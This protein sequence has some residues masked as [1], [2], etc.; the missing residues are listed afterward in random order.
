MPPPIPIYALDY[1]GR[2]NLVGVSETRSGMFFAE[3]SISKVGSLSADDLQEFGKCVYGPLRSTSEEAKSDYNLFR[4]GANESSSSLRRIIARLASL[5][6]TR[7]YP[8]P[9]ITPMLSQNPSMT[10]NVSPNG[11]RI[12][13]IRRPK[14]II[15]CDTQSPV[16]VMERVIDLL[17]DLLSSVVDSQLGISPP[18]SELL[19]IVK[20]ALSRDRGPCPVSSPIIDKYIKPLIN[21]FLSTS[22][23]SKLERPRADSDDLEVIHGFLSQFMDRARQADIAGERKQIKR[24]NKLNRSRKLTKHTLFINNIPKEV[25]EQSIF[26][27]FETAGLTDSKAVYKVVI[28]RDNSTNESRGFGRVIFRN[29]KATMAA[30]EESRKWEIA[31][32]HLYLSPMPTVASTES[33]DQDPGLYDFL[34]SVKR[35]RLASYKLPDSTSYRVCRILLQHGEVVI[36]DLPNLVPEIGEFAKYGFQNL[37]QAVRSIEGVRIDSKSKHIVYLQ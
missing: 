18:E 32:K 16:R 31:G 34:P 9:A 21:V 3:Y 23:W 6:G 26:D 36:S 29:A 2:T 4:A 8:N 14:I 27:L 17:T 11:I 35:S 1:Q 15:T 12:G 25:D 22:P 28:V 13:G 7:S 33:S 20:F 19:E 30:I 24:M 37:T 5:G 10:I